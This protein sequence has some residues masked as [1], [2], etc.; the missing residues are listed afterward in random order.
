MNEVSA[1]TKLGFGAQVMVI[2]L[3]VVFV[4]LCILILATKLLTLIIVKARSA[5]EEKAQVQAAATPAQPAPTAAPAIE[6]PAAEDDAQL[7]A[8]I[9]A[10]IAAYSGSAKRLVVRSV[11][12]TG[13][14]S[15][16]ANAG[17]R[18][19]LS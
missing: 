14:G 3:V 4:G 10:A 15:A 5:R 16:W 7:I 1:L 8:V 9:S 6:I 12:K 19:Q 17:R 2:G 18:D 11:R 13:A